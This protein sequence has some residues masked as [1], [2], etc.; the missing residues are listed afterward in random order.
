M[1]KQTKPW[2]RRALA[3][4]T[5]DKAE[6]NEVRKSRIW[7]RPWLWRGLLLSVVVGIIAFGA[8]Q[9]GTSGNLTPRSV[10][11][12]VI[13]QPLVVF[14]LVLLPALSLRI[15]AGRRVRF[16]DIVQAISLSVLLFKL[17]PGRLS[18]E[19]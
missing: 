2:A 16:R 12:V 13:V 1:L 11:A 7:Y 15:L 6:I 10:W 14:S 18:E 4:A 9:S 8:I 19:F 5:R 3:D 17:L